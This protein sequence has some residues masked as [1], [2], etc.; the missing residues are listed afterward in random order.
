MGRLRHLANPEANVLKLLEYFELSDSAN[1][2]VST[3][4]GGIKRKLD[5]AM[6]LVGS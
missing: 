5:I 4:S 2:I 6:S 1:Q 3:Y